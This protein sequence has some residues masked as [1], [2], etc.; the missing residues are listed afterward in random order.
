[1]SIIPYI[2]LSI[3]DVNA[4]I[5][6]PKVGGTPQGSMFINI[7]GWRCGSRNFTFNEQ[8]EFY[9]AKTTLTLSCENLRPG[10]IFPLV[11]SSRRQ[12]PTDYHKD[13]D[14][15]ANGSAII[16][17]VADLDAYAISVES[18]GSGSVCVDVDSPAGWVELGCFDPSSTTHAYL[19]LGGSLSVFPRIRIRST[20]SCSLSVDYGGLKGVPRRPV[21]ASLLVSDTS[22]GEI[23]FAS[24]G[25][26][27]VGVINTNFE[28]TP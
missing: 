23:L 13:I 8:G 12:F 27:T 19:V 11:L 14:I 1:M 21:L 5:I 26:D 28:I 16:D 15:P 7:L 25:A 20:V 2:V 17:R 10:L 18:G 24:Y 3:L 22:T 4:V 6:I 9:V